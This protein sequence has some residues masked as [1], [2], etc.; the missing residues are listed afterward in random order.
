MLS[1]VRDTCSWSKGCVVHAH[2]DH[3]NGATNADN[4]VLMRGVALILL[5]CPA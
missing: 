5:S 4:A 3:G 2:Y 1:A